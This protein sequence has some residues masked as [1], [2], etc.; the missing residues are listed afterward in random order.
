[1]SDEIMV[2]IE[3]CIVR[4]EWLCAF[5]CDKTIAENIR[6]FLMQVR[7]DL[8]YEYCYS[9]NM[10]ILEKATQTRINPYIKA[11]S[12]YI[13]NGITFQLY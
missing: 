12:M 1:M 5:D 6:S 3:V 2:I 10:L 7:D 13:Y 9:E 11:N 8:D 4:R